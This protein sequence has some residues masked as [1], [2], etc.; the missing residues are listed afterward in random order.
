MTTKKRRKKKTKERKKRRLTIELVLPLHGVILCR[1]RLRLPLLLSLVSHPRRRV[2][3]EGLGDLT[4][5]WEEDVQRPSRRWVDPLDLEQ[6]VRGD[7]GGVVQPQEAGR[8]GDEPG[9]HYGD[10]LT[11]QHGGEWRMLEWIEVLR[12]EMVVVMWWCAVVVLM[13]CGGGGD[14][15]VMS[16]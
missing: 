1:L 15:V 12:G 14:V 3:L 8:D 7:V 2:R 10:E 11:N 6:E 9:Y 4:A 16:W 13:W 5:E